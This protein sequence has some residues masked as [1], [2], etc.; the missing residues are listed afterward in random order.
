MKSIVEI[1]NIFFNAKHTGCL[2]IS[3][4][5]DFK[6]NCRVYFYKGNIYAAEYLNKVG[7]DALLEIIA[8]KDIKY[9]FFNNKNINREDFSIDT[10]TVINKLKEAS[11]LELNKKIRF[12]AEEREVSFSAKEWKILALSQHKIN[13]DNLIKLS[14]YSKE[15]VLKIVSGLKDKGIIELVDT[16]EEKEE[17][18]VNSRKY[19]PRVFWSTL[20]AELS[21]TLGPVT[22][23]I[24]L[25]EIY[26]LEEDVDKFPINKLPLLIEKLASEIDNPKVR[27]DFQ[28]KMLATIKKL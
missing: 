7:F 12:I 1:L 19:T 5:D 2:F 23:E 27:L 20:S 17:N 13:L 14:A 21:K 6:K 16:W 3:D 28:K 4:G 24:I 9:K 11:M 15:E 26:N 18:K 22:K 10:L 25:D 8:F